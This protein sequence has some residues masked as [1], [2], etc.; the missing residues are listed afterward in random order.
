EAGD[1][2]RQLGQDLLF[3]ADAKDWQEAQSYFEK[4]RSNYAQARADGRKVAAALASRDKMFA[5]I[6]YYAR[7][8]ASYRG[9]HPQT[10]IDRLFDRAE[11]GFFAAHG[12]AEITAKSPPP[13]DQLDK[14]DKLREEADGH[15]KA[16]ADLFDT[17]TS[18]LTNVAM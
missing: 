8:L 9:S 10:Q 7:W 6:P 4:A 5:R 12:I 2:N 3:S 17:D 11:A 14:L 16:I 13:L 1:R 15:F 18:G